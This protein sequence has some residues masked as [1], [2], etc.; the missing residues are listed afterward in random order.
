MKEAICL[1]FTDP[2][3]RII[4]HEYTTFTLCS[5]L[6][7]SHVQYTFTQTTYADS[8]LQNNRTVKRMKQAVPQYRHYA[9]QFE[10][11]GTTQF[12]SMSLKR[13]DTQRAPTI[14]ESEWLAISNLAIP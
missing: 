10:I 8:I 4:E 1:C 5:T 11:V 13:R 9:D 12:H 14:E 7:E 6:S 3:K 2:A